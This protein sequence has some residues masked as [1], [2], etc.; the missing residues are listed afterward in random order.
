MC[1][2]SSS[3][4][5]TAPITASDAAEMEETEWRRTDTCHLDTSSPALISSLPFSAGKSNIGQHDMSVLPSVRLWAFT[6]PLL[7]FSSDSFV[8][9]MPPIRSK[10]TSSS[11]A[12][13]T[14]EFGQKTEV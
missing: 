1:V 4:C 10:L 7:P 12:H 5:L 9:S 3:V 11:A 6:R 14:S 13:F 8:C 2:L